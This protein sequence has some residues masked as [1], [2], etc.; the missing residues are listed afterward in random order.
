M[1]VCLC[2]CGQLV[3]K[4]GSHLLIARYCYKP[5]GQSIGVLSKTK[6]TE[7]CVFGERQL[8]LGNCFV[9]LINEVASNFALVKNYEGGSSHKKLIC[10]SKFFEIYH[11]ILKYY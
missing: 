1:F 6:P 11:L 9:I 7:D 5:K 2:V 3:S 4:S 10:S 8:V